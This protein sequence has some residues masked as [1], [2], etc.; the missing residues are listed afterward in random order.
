MSDSRH[1]VLE[2]FTH[3]VIELVMYFKKTINMIAAKMVQKNT[4]ELLKAEKKL[5]L[6]DVR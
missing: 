2:T 4:S 6:G 3:I 1:V 5:N